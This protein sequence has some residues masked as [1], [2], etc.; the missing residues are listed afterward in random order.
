MAGHS[1]WA[2]IKNRKASVDAKKSKTF[3]IVSKLITI[4]V[5]E[6]GSS[7]P[8][9]NPRLRLALEKARAANMPNVNIQKAIDKG[10]GKSGGVSIE[11]IV[12]EGFGPGGVGIIVRVLSDNRNRTG[13]EIKY[14]FDRNHGTLAGPGSVSYMFER[15]QDSYTVK[16]PVPVDASTAKQVDDLLAA[17][18]DHEDVELVVSNKAEHE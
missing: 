3:A 9:S 4:A 17:L 5:K 14:I 15:A 6:G 2:N 10:M 16:V 7:N 11:E 1:K 12:Y 13:S 8:E 18:N